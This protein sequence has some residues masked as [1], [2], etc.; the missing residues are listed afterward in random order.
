MISIVKASDEQMI[1]EALL[2]MESI[3]L[4]EECRNRLSKENRFPVFLAPDGEL[5]DIDEEEDL[6]VW[7]SD[8]MYH[9]YGWALLKEEYNYVSEDDVSS[10]FEFHLLFVSENPED[11]ER[12]RAELAK[13]EPTLFHYRIDRDLYP[14][15][16]EEALVKKKIRVTACG[17]LALE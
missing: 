2:R 14:D 13:M 8:N 17:G 6:M 11:W 5:A 12:E 7:E 10:G 4:S 16:T 9:G 15:H 1:S 3:G